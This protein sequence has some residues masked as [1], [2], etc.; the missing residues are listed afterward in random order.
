VDLKKRKAK[1]NNRKPLGARLHSRLPHITYLEL[2]VVAN[3]HSFGA[4]A[5]D[6]LRRCPGVKKLD[7]D[8]PSESQLEVI[9][10]II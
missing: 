6:V 8:F 4:N 1:E 10:L 2:C 9:L 7:L 3:G 5:F